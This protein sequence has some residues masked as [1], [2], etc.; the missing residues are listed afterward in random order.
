MTVVD[1]IMFT[2]I[3]FWKE[4]VVSRLCVIKN[5]TIVHLVVSEVNLS[6]AYEM[7]TPSVRRRQTDADRHV[8]RLRNSM[9]DRFNTLVKMHLSFL[10]DLDGSKLE[11]IIAEQQSEPLQTQKRKSSTPFSKR[12]SKHSSSGASNMLFGSPLTDENVARI[13]QLIEFLGRPE[14]LKTE[15]LFRKTGNFARQRLLKEW[16]NES[17]DLCLDSGTFTAHDC[18][19]VMKN[20]LGE[21]PEPLLT[22]RHYHAHLQVGDMA[23]SAVLEKEKLRARAKQLKT[24]QLLFLL[25]PRTNV[26]LL[27]C[28]IDLLHKVANIPDNMMT[29]TALGT[30]FAPH[31]ICPRKLPAEE[32]KSVSPLI[33]KA[34]S[35][36]IENG[37]QIFKVPKE[38]AADIANY[39]REM[40][41]PN[42]CTR[43][44]SQPEST[45]SSN[46]YNAKKYS[47][48]QV[49]NTVVSFTQR[50]PSSE[51]E[52]S[53]ETQVALAKLYAHVQ[54]MPESAKKKKLLKQF[55]RASNPSSGGK[56]SRSR[57]LGEQIKKHFSGLHRSHKRR[58]SND[59]SQ[60]T[61]DLPWGITKT[62]D[63]DENENLHDDVFTCVT[64]QRSISMKK[65][66]SPAVHIVDL[67]RTPMTPQARKRH[68]SD[69][70]NGSIPE[71][72]PTPERLPCSE[73]EIRYMANPPL[74]HRPY[75]YSPQPSHH[76]KPV[77]M[78]SPI[79]HSPI[80]N[81]V[82]KA[83]P[84]L[85]KEMKTPGS[86]KPMMILNSPNSISRESIL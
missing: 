57:T 40:E 10:L 77:A 4:E 22:E 27:E 38:L 24:Q 18:A 56:H 41:T 68:G 17:V 6:T 34:V 21:L 50:K 53:N 62:I 46:L 16:L 45:S 52:S 28:L 13:Y 29:A 76:G 44:H 63:I 74:D 35:F 51:S 58:N 55:N 15:G 31:L 36:M 83:H 73:N 19:T 43:P 32:L 39:W 20:Y 81:S 8:N 78:V 72:R 49:I 64:P 1:P 5:A 48:S 2:L 65:P 9:P 86:R 12:K 33:T 37:S 82:K 23:T 80:T 61:A 71:K 25:L 3:S 47:S 26:L 11:E 79:S 30:M 42:K 59:Q 84:K 75:P 60:C 14:N 85:Q 54:M 69:S 66:S 7:S 70:S 67:G